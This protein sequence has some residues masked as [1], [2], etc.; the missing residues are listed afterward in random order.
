M[1]V[2][3]L[4][5]SLTETALAAHL[6]SAGGTLVSVRLLLHS[7]GARSKG[8][9]LAEFSSAAEAAAAVAALNDTEIGGRLILVRE[10][11][12]AALHLGAQRNLRI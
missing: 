3:N 10:D 8:C 9:A 1:Y 7:D 5:W 4:P 11:R 12:E 6:S 2:H